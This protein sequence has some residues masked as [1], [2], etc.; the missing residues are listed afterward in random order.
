[1]VLTVGETKMTG[2]ELLEFSEKGQHAS[3]IMNAFVHCMKLDDKADGTKGYHT[4]R[5]IVTT[6]DMVSFLQEAKLWM[7]VK[8]SDSKLFFECRM[9]AKHWCKR[10]SKSLR[11]TR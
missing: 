6:E 7:L 1:V 8:R 2:G 10:L 4:K 5:I 9:T 3:S 11:P